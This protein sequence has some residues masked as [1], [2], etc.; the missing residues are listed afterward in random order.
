ME[1]P[2]EIIRSARRKKTVSARLVNGTIEV[3]APAAISERDLQP[4]IDN[5][6]KRLQKQQRKRQLNETGDLQRRAQELNQRY[7]HGE[8]R[9][10]K[11]EYVTNQEKRLGSCTASRGTI[12]ISHRM[13][14]LPKWVVDYILVHEIAHLKEPN[15]SRKFWALVNRYPLAE[16]ARGY[17]MAINLEE[18]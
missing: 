17:L 13:A 7:F 5:L 15:H 6:R 2:I 4:I 9:I 14:G 3:R 12:R 11:I 1:Y 10:R 16:R 18:E 8:L